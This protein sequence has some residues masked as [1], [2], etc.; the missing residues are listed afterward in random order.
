MTL[1]DHITSLFDAQAARLDSYVAAHS[2]MHQKLAEQVVQAA[3]V[4]DQRLEGMN[5]LRAQI[6]GERGQYVTR[7]VLDQRNGA[8]ALRIEELG[9]RVDQRF[10]E[11]G[12]RITEMERA[13]ANMD[14]RM[15]ML[16]LMLLGAS[17]VLNLI[18][19][20][21]TRAFH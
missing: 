3:K 20:I 10:E 18:I 15:A 17:A 16:G 8:L 19:S 14:G 1:R 6:T 9:R 2:E 4:I 12:K 7:D 21:A 11:T 13:K 5:E